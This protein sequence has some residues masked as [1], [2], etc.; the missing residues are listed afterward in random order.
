MCLW[1]KLAQRTL[2]EPDIVSLQR[3]AH[4]QLALNSTPAPMHICKA[5]NVK[6]LLVIG[7]KKSAGPTDVWI[8]SP[9]TSPEVSPSHLSIDGPPIVIGSGLGMRSET[10]ASSA[11]FGW[12]VE[13]SAR[14]SPPPPPGCFLSSWYHPITTGV[15]IHWSTSLLSLLLC[16]FMDPQVSFLHT[17]ITWDFSLFASLVIILLHAF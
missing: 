15:S 16:I 3:L 7:F 2:G 11:N 9:P 5:S 12:W 13:G 8:D 6:F 10:S 17:L 14:H 4:V 1:Y